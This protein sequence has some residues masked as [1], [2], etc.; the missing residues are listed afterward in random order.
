MQHALTAPS[1]ALV[2]NRS[3]ALLAPC[4]WLTSVGYGTCVTS[5]KSAAAFLEMVAKGRVLVVPAEEYDRFEA[6]AAR[7]RRMGNMSSIH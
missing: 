3:R 6:E 2:Q 4:P 7:M 1:C 5:M